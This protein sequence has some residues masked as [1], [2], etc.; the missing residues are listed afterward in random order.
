MKKYD[1]ET[2]LYYCFTLL[3]LLII[4]VYIA[5]RVNTLEKSVTSLRN[6]LRAQNERMGL[7]NYYYNEHERK[8]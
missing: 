8:Q 3:F 7:R 2:F 6:D 1:L 4:G 5:N